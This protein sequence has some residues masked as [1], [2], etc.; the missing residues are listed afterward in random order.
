[1]PQGGFGGY[2]AQVQNGAEKGI[3]AKGS[4]GGIHDQQNY[5]DVLGDKLNGNLFQADILR[6][7]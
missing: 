5:R 2:L 7:P 4:D 6:G 1:L 3:G